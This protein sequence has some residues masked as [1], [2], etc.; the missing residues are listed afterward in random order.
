MP[1]GGEWSR[2]R[3]AVADDAGDDQ[4]WVVVGG[5]VRVRDRVSKL[6]ALVDRA[7]RLGSHVTGNTTRERELGEE[8]F[9]TLLVLGDVWVDFA[10]GSLKVGIGDQARTAVSGAG[11]VKHV[12]VV[13]LN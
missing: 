11:D 6:A 9:H 8:P 5:S 13:L 4:V 7:W 12:K 1:A 2:L 3:L 10:I